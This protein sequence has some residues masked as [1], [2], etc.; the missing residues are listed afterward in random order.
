MKH[1]KLAGFIVRF[2]HVILAV[3]VAAAAVCGVLIPKVNINSD[4]TKYLPDSS[5]MKQGVDIMAEEF[6]D[7]TQPSTLRLMI[8]DLPEEEKPQIKAFLESVENVS[9]VAWEAEN[10]DYNNGDKTLYVIT[11]DYAFDSDEEAAIESAVNSEMTGRDYMLEQMSNAAPTAPMNVLLLAGVLLTVILLAM[12]GSWFEP[13]VY[14]LVIGVAI[15]LNMGTNVF[16]PSVSETT[17]SIA[18]VLQL[19]L[20]MDYSIILM[21]RYKQEF[22]RNPD[23][24]EAMKNALVNAFSSITSSAVTTFVGLLMLLFMSFKIGADLGIV[25]AKGVLCSLLC[26]FTVL[27]ALILLFHKVIFK[28]EKRVLKIPTDALAKFSVRMRVPLTVLF[29]LFFA[30]TFYLQTKTDISFSVNLSTGIRDYFTAD[31]TAVVLF[32]NDDSDRVQAIVDEVVKDDKV[33]AAVSYPTLIGKESTADVLL[34]E[35]AALTDE[36]ELEPWMLRLIYYKYHNGDRLPAVTAAELIRF[37]SDEILPNPFFAAYLD[38]DLKDNAALLE[39][40]SD[41]STL[42]KPMNAKELGAFF[43]RDADELKQLFVLYYA[44][45]DNVKTAK[46]TMPG[47]VDFIKTDILTDKTYAAMIDKDMAA[48]LDRL[49]AFTDKKT[50]QQP[51]TA[52]EMAGFLGVEESQLRAAYLL[53]NG[54]FRAGDAISPY[55]LIT[56]M[57]TNETVGGNLDEETKAQLTTLAGIMEATVNET[58][59]DAAKLSEITGMKQADAKQL[60]L[61]Y[62]VKHGDTSSWKMSPRAFVKF[63][64][65]AVLPNPA[66]ASLIDASYRDYLAAADVL[67]DAVVSEKTYSA[68]QLAELFGGLS[69][70]MD[71]T[72]LRLLLTYYGSV[73]DYD[74]ACTMSLIGLFDYLG[75]DLINDP[76]FG[77]VLDDSVKAQINEMSPV[78]KQAVASLRREKHSL[79]QITS[80]YPDESPETMAFMAKLNTLCDAHLPKE[81]YVIGSSQMYYEMSQTFRHEMLV[82]TLLTAISIFIIVLLSFRNGLIPLLLVL[83]VQCGVFVTAAVSYLRG[84]SLNYLAYLIVQCILMG[85]TIDYGILFTNYYREFRKTLSPDKALP[86]AY[87]NSVHTILTSGLIM[88]GVTGAIGYT[89]QIPTIGPICRTVSIGSLSA[90]LL[91]LF[92]LPGMLTAADRLIVKRDKPKKKPKD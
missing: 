48:Q 56:Y 72:T 92:V 76:V 46:I 11:T 70:Q 83:I 30:A 16:K 22:R 33:R 14:L 85:A 17:F 59:C 52:A 81:H 6:A 55:E 23:K 74:E 54:L 26:V 50:I 2:R 32:D 43:G 49:T 10:A 34:N 37:I 64:R 71:E 21:N 5:N 1:E 90:V 44:D 39:Q 38:D 28:T 29:A 47:F 78:M 40:F 62:T 12:S 27:P 13:V 77:S 45:K 15:L 84:Y 18:A 8:T 4:M 79:L 75:S 3:I 41:K 63:V 80:K 20:S 36:F 9:S 91:I 35:I 82:M 42:T 88:I 65:S 87:H 24:T 89:T 53:H 86:E 57:L 51:M 67:I 66:Y 25:L 7:L 58:A 19:V 73:H 68:P 31:N 69:D 61:L 60:L